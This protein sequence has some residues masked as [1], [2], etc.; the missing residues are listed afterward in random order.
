[1]SNHGANT[2]DMTTTD[3]EGKSLYRAAGW[4]V[5]AAGF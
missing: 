1:M 4:K 2:I 3:R 5:R